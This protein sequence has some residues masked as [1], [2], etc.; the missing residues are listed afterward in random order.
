VRDVSS[1]TTSPRAFGDRHVSQITWRSG[2]PAN[3][4]L[5]ERDLSFR[6]H[7]RKHFRVS[8]PKLVLFS[9]LSTFTRALSRLP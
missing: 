1:Q 5:V 6:A 3:R 7:S 9:P 2:F 8:R 4:G